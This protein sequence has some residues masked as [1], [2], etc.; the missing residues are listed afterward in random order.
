MIQEHHLKVQRTARFYTIG[1]LTEKTRNIWFCLHG[2][3][4]LAQYF[5]RKFTDLASDETLIVVPEGLSRSYLD[6]NYQRVGASWMTREDAQHEIDDYVAYLNSLYSRI[7]EE[8]T[9][10]NEKRHITVFGFSQGAATACRWLNNGGNASS[11][12]HVDRLVLWAGY[13]PKGLSDLI[14]ANVL[15]DT[16][17]HYV[18]GRQ[19]EYISAIADLD[20]YLNRLQDDV[21]NLQITAFE[22]SHRVEPD[23]L[24]SLVTAPKPIA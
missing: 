21:P 20:A 15:T 7:L 17:T 12:I 18:Y 23:V 8:R 19:D 3:G 2:F 13:F 16:E 6:M 9:S 1:Q 14:S 10:L 24:K 11:R 5:G 4:Q 22:G